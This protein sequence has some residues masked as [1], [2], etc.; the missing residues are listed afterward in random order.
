MFF[1]TLQPGTM[2]GGANGKPT[3]GSK[4]RGLGE[5]GTG[6]ETAR[7]MSTPESLAAVKEETAVDDLRG[8]LIGKGSSDVRAPLAPDGRTPGFDVPAMIGTP[9]QAGDGVCHRASR[10][11]QDRLVG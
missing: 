10:K 3:K 4:C 11:R 5:G 6:G 2:N 8:V 7:G 1:R 9:L